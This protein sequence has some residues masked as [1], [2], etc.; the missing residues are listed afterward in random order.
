MSL[1]WP[2]TV[3]IVGASE[4]AQQTK[5]GVLEFGEC[6]VHLTFYTSVIER[7]EML[8]SRATLCVTEVGKTVCVNVSFY[9]TFQKH[10]QVQ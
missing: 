8:L 4:A 9:R 7:S 5:R 1:F 6:T 2:L 10:H 3:T